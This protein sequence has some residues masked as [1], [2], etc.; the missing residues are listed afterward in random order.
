MGPI[1]RSVGS[2]PRQRPGVSSEPAAGRR[3]RQERGDGADAGEQDRGGRLARDLEETA[4]P[5]SFAE[6]C[7][8]VEQVEGV[9]FRQLFEA[10]PR[11]AASADDALAQVLT[12][13]RQRVPGQ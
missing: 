1:R 11:R 13:A 6:V 2:N 5:S 4:A 10:L 3:G 8:A 7:A 9:R 12:L